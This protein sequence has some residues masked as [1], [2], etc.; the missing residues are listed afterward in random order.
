[1][2]KGVNTEMAAWLRIVRIQFYPMTW[3]AYSLGAVAARGATGRF[4]LAA[5]GLGYL[6]LFLIELA[7]ILCNEYYDYPSDKVNHNASPFNGGSRVLVEGGLGF[8]Q[9]KTAIFIV[10]L[11]IVPLGY[12]LARIAVSGSMLPILLS[13]AAGIFL[14]LGYTVPPLKFSHR[15]LGEFVVGLTHSAYV[16]LCGYIF[17]GGTW[18][19][20]LPWI[21]SVPLFFATLAAIS[22]AGIPDRAADAAVSKRTFAVLVGS[23]WAAIISMCSVTAAAVSAVMFWYLGPAG[24]Y[25]GVGILL[26]VPHGLILGI[27]VFRLITSSNYDRRIDRIMQLALSYIVWFGVLPLIH[28]LRG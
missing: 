20:P 15:G 24:S 3:V 27:A 19:S 2:S 6:V 22:L 28:L 12:L 18:S 25:S 8:A 23:R 11:S 26:V 17:Q 10:V 14:G 7:T 1:M 13:I 21:Q 5:Y 4:D 9:V 16:I